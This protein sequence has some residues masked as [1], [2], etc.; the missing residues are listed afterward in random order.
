MHTDGAK[1]EVI[2]K[3]GSE[4]TTKYK[5]LCTQ[6]GFIPK[7]GPEHCSPFPGKGDTGAQQTTVLVG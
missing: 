2:S 4:L 3:F 6:V 5:T 1:N 7:S